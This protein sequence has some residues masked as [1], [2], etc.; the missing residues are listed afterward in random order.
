MLN[1][2][3]ENV[4]TSY[5]WTWAIVIIISLMFSHGLSSFV[6]LPYICM[7]PNYGQGSP[8]ASKV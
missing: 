5:T 8:K 3:I 6:Y 2:K 1:L 4:N 7:V